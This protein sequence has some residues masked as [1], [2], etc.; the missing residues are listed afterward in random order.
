MKIRRSFLVLLMCVC[1]FPAAYA[2]LFSV[3]SESAVA[4]VVPSWMN[5]HTVPG[6]AVVVYVD[7]KPSTYFYGLANKEAK[8]P[9]TEDTIFEM[10]DVS[11]VMTNL[12][13]AQ[14]VDY[15][16]IVLKDSLK[17]YDEKLPEEVDE[18]TIQDIATQTADFPAI[19]PANINTSSELMAYLAAAQ[20]GER[21]GEIWRPSPLSDSVLAYVL[22]KTTT[23]EYDWL[24]FHHI[25]GLLGMHHL[26]ANVP[27]KYKNVVASGYKRDGSPVEAASSGVFLPAL[28][29][30]E[31]AADMVKFLGAAIGL[32]GTPERVLYPMKMTQSVFVKLGDRM[33]GLGW[34]IYSLDEGKSSVLNKPVVPPAGALPVASV[35]QQ[36]LYDG[37]QM[38]EKTGSANGFAAYMAVIP[39][40]NA[41]IVIMANKQ[42]PEEMIARVGREI[43]FKV[44]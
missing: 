15:A 44:V 34:Q 3:S 14:E 28:G 8:A 13:V 21:A 5:E 22:E 25:S 29:V 6:V 11:S 4:G 35:L 39:N 37:N 33:Q 23:K 30:K 42:V 41:G 10:A 12:L 18:I 24:Y 32:P 7:G 40:K 43:L 9:V 27:D 20:Y 19:P 1:F 2:G 31:S 38:M 16:N 17:K 36:P 26:G